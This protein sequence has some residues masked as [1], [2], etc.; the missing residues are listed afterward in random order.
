MKTIHRAA[1]LALGAT[2]G[3]ALALSGSTPASAATWEL[4]DFQ[5]QQQICVQ[6]GAHRD[7]YLVAA[8]VGSWSTTVRIGLRNLPPGSTSAGGSQIPPGSNYTNPETG[9]TVLNGFVQI[10]VAPLPAGVYNLLLTASDGT[11]TQSN[12]VAIN[13][14]DRCY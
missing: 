4:L 1:R 14:K 3:L 2:A 12:P 5:P 7:T 13:V 11:E 9:S 8:V 10:S 6:P